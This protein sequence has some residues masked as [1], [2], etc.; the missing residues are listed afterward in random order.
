VKNTVHIDDALFADGAIAN[1]NQPSSAIISGDSLLLTKQG[2][3]WRV[4]LPNAKDV[5]FLVFRDLTVPQV[6]NP[7]FIQLLTPIGD[8]KLTY[9]SDSYS[10]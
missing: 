1:P 4:S 6:N 5:A 2:S 7:T 10:K 3:A 9:A 8:A